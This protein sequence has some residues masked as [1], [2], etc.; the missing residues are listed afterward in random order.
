MT[1]NFG[2]EK[3]IKLL[4]KYN[5]KINSHILKIDTN[6]VKMHHA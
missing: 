3:Y 6:Y 1:E 5:I 2:I 4:Y